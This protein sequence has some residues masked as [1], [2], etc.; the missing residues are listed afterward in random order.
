[1]S[2]LLDARF[3]ASFFVVLRQPD[4]D[5]FMTPIAIHGISPVFIEQVLAIAIFCI[6]IL[7]VMIRY[8]WRRFSPHVLREGGALPPLFV[9]PGKGAIYAVGALWIFS[10]VFFAVT[11]Y[12]LVSHVIDAQFVDFG[13]IFLLLMATL[14]LA[15]TTVGLWLMKHVEQRR[16]DT[17]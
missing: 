13:A 16:P 15:V 10:A 6:W 3:T 8:A 1:M 5:A 12:M 2:V 7:L 9:A 14:P 11:A 17:V 4:G